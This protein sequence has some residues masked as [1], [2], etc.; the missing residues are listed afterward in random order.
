MT[1]FI[2]HSGQIINITPETITVSIAQSSACSECHAKG[3][4]TSADVREKK[5]SVKNEGQK[6]QL[7]DQVQVTGKSSIGWQAVTIAFIIPC[8]LVVATLI[9][10]SQA[11]IDDALSG[12]LSLVVLVPYF[13]IVSRF[14]NALKRHLSFFITKTNLFT[15]I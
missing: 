15:S 7:G 10:G 14:E 12:L 3:A 2:E 5:I 9:Y 11:K 1:K 8:I 13:I 4:C 6:V